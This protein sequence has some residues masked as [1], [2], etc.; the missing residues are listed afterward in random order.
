MQM[1]AL[2]KLCQT[3][4]IHGQKRNILFIIVFVV[5]VSPYYISYI[6]ETQYLSRHVAYGGQSKQHFGHLLSLGYSMPAAAALSA[7]KHKIEGV[8]PFHGFPIL[9]SGNLRNGLKNVF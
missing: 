5:G 2:P 8:G 6:W 4:L 3:K 9:T 1:S 7:R